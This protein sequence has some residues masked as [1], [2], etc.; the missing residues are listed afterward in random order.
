MRVEWEEK[1]R[2]QHR[3]FRGIDFTAYPRI[4]LVM[5]KTMVVRVPGHG[6]YSGA[7]NPT[8]YNPAC[9]CVL[10]PKGANPSFP[11]TEINEGRLSRKKLDECREK[12][13]TA[14]G[15]DSELQMDVV[16]DA[17]YKAFRQ[18]KTAVVTD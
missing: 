2:E 6:F 18:K 15:I 11:Y 8:N 9:L 5:G 3:H 12:L 14:L 1:Q 16:M 13:K 7:M 10:N 17:I 4:L